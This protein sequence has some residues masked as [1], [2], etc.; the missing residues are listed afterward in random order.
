MTLDLALYALTT[1]TQAPGPV[2][3]R[4]RGSRRQ[5]KPTGTVRHPMS[6][7]KPTIRHQ[8]AQLQIFEGLLRRAPSLLL[9]APTNTPSDLPNTLH[10]TYS[11]SPRTGKSCDV[12]A[13]MFSKVSSPDSN[14]PLPLRD[15]GSLSQGIRDSVNALWSRPILSN[16]EHWPGI[17]CAKSFTRTPFTFCRMKIATRNIY[18]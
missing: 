13:S 1:K 11:Q 2:G 4:R 3:E 6:A 12:P 5:P 18:R 14:L 15:A 17:E 9:T 8:G 7:W 10:P 16:I